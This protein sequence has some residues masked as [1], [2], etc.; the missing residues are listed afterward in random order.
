MAAEAARKGLSFAYVIVDTAAAYNGGDDENSNNQAGAY[1]RQLRTLTN[2]PGG[3]CVGP[4]PATG[5][6]SIRHMA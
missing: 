2:L 3:P 5:R 6:P 4:M 1:A